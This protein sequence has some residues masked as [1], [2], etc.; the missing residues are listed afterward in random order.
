MSDIEIWGGPECTVNRVADRW[1]DQSEL[2][3]HSHRVQDLELIANLG[4]RTLRYPVLWERT[5]PKAPL[6]LNWGWADERLTKLRALS[7]TPIVGLLHHGSGPAYSGLLESE[8]PAALAEFAS[9]VAARYPWVTRYTPINEP[10]T[11]A[12]FSALYGHWYPHHR[13]DRSFARALINQCRAIALSMKAIRRV[14]PNAELVQTEDL[15]TTHG[16]AHMAYQQ[17]FDNERRWLTWD[18]LCGRVDRHHPLRA[19]LLGCGIA[20]GELDWFEANPCPPQVIG[21]NHYVTSDRY[22]D[23]RLSLYPP[24]THG[25]NS[26]ERYADVDAVRALAGN[27]DG[28]SVIKG[29]AARYGLPVALTEVHLGCTREEQLRWFHEAHV[30][31]REARREGFPVI[32]ITAWSLFGAYNWDKLLTKTD[33]SYEPGAFDVRGPLPRP[34]AIAKHIQQAISGGSLDSHLD[35]AGWWQRPDRVLYGAHGPAHAGGRQQRLS[36]PRPLLIFGAGGVLGRVYKS[37]CERRNLPFVAVSRTDLDNSDPAAVGAL[38]DAAKPWAIVNAAGYVRV[39]EAEQDMAQ[40]FRDNVVGSCT[41]AAAAA[42]RHIPFL[43]FSSD[44]VFDGLLAAPYTESCPTAPLNVYGKSK[45]AAE[46]AT[47]LFP[48]TLCVRTAAFF[49]AG[50]GSDFLSNALQALRRGQRYRVLEDVTVSPT[51]VPDLVEASLDL[52]ID[53]CTGLVHLVNGGAVTW[54]AFLERGAK[55]SGVKTRSVQR[56]CLAELGL[57]AARPRYSALSSERVWVM[58]TLD[59]AIARYSHTAHANGGKELQ[60]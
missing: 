1:Y 24:H 34:T 37:I 22:L 39:D 47:L 17:Q 11:T 2:S 16:T 40:C 4:I 5:A 41:L 15:G 10:M 9:N 30:K 27:Y 55:A 12:R 23:E 32:A 25:G 45:V 58:P 8:F 7:I 52:L 56:S 48:N 20:A 53:G 14:T 46:V 19:F 59:D 13:D 44:L 21:I 57:P 49:G 18:L 51:Y 60:H 42:D 54:S 31:A 29:A 3:G 36:P 6:E 43:T 28:W 38:C 50:N 35:G 33:G 26:T